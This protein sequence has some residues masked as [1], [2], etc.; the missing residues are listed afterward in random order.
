MTATDLRSYRRAPDPEHLLILLM[1]LTALP[2]WEWSDLIFPHLRSVW[3]SIGPGIYLIRVGADDA[4]VQTRA[5]R[6]LTRNLLDRRLDRA[7]AAGKGRA[8]PLAHG[9]VLALESSGATSSKAE[10][11]YDRHV[12]WPS[13]T[14]VATSRSRWSPT[15]G[16][17]GEAG[18][19]AS[20]TLSPDRP[21]LQGPA[22]RGREILVDPGPD[23]YEDLVTQLAAALGARVVRR[24]IG[25][26]R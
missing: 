23:A 26:T 16:F 10:G 20:R 14:D 25:S 11:P 5:Q 18:A 12:S 3:T 17:P 2:D 7:L 4:P 15:S 19:S 13:P 24:S 8:T 1:D 22:E 21:G 9:L 6:L